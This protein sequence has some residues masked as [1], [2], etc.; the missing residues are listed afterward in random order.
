ME[1]PQRV[2]ELVLRGIFLAREKEFQWL[3]QG[4]FAVNLIVVFESTNN[5]NCRSWSQQSLS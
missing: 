1:Y 5:G 2:S 4:L 3:Y